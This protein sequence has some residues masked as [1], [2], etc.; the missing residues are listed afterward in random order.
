MPSNLQPG[1][2]R[3]RPRKPNRPHRADRLR[4]RW[5]RTG[6]LDCGDA[7]HFVVSLLRMDNRSFKERLESGQ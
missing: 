4:G 2:L 1:E 7:I 5:A 6:R 3:L